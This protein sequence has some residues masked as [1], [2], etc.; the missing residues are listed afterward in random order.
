MCLRFQ[1]WRAVD[2]KPQFSDDIA[3]VGSSMESLQKYLDALVSHA[4]EVGLHMNASKTKF[5]STD[6]S[7]KILQPTIYGKNI[8][9]VSDFVYLGHKLSSINDGTA[10]VSHRI[11]LGWA[12]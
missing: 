3:A 8:E 1:A 10:A 11:G 9:C 4:E 6:K 5:M 12:A 2:I 7:Q